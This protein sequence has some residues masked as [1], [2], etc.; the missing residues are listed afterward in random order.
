[1]LD[2]PICQSYTHTAHFVTGNM[3]PKHCNQA[4][5]DKFQITSITSNA[6]IVTSVYR[7][8]DANIHVLNTLTKFIQDYSKGHIV[9]GD[10]NFCQR[11]NPNHSVKKLLQNNHFHPAIVPPT[12][13]HTEGRYL[14]QIYIRL[15][16]QVE[17]KNI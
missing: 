11:N 9:M 7:S 16:L 2:F 12:S 14:G 10:M 6:L 3:G 17:C 1:M 15:T 4:T 8:T 13:T 5:E